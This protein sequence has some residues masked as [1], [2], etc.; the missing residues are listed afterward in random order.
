MPSTATLD[1]VVVHDSLASAPHARQMTALQN[2]GAHSLG[3]QH[4]LQMTQ[5]VEAMK[6]MLSPVH[7]RALITQDGHD[8]HHVEHAQEGGAAVQ[9]SH[10]VLH[11]S[12]TCSCKHQQG[13][14]GYRNTSFDI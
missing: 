9:H 12:H 8:A 13:N 4:D 14:R 1:M 5:H 2:A 10:D 11:I 7:D 3:L 6:R